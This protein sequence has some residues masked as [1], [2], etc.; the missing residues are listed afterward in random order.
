MYR[1]RTGNFYGNRLPDRKTHSVSARCR[2]SEDKIVG[3]RSSVR[4]IRSERFISWRRPYV[5]IVNE[6]RLLMSVS[7]L[8]FGP[9]KSQSVSVT[10][11]PESPLLIFLL[12]GRVSLH[13]P[14]G[15][16]LLDIAD[17]VCPHHYVLVQ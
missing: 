15:E 17:L 13:I 16:H 3:R 14:K 11:P 1:S 8:V 4:L 10:I 7:E 12:G 6:N 5:R 9:K 2:A